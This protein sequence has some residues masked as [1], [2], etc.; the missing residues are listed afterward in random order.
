VYFYFFYFHP[1]AENGTVAGERHVSVQKAATLG[2]SLT[3]GL[4]G[5]LSF[6]SPL[7]GTDPFMWTSFDFVFSAMSIG[8]ASGLVAQ[9]APNVLLRNAEVN[10][11]DAE[12]EMV[13]EGGDQSTFFSSS[14]PPDFE[15]IRDVEELQR[16]N[17]E[18]LRWEESEKRVWN[19]EKRQRWA[20]QLWEAQHFRRRER[21]RVLEQAE[22][23]QAR[24][25]SEE[26]RER[27]RRAQWGPRS[28]QYA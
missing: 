8:A 9:M 24:R 1:R 20:Q 23:D 26:F 21:R 18:W 16:T 12:M 5:V 28:T 15:R 25:Q 22:R 13:G 2:G 10:K 17:L 19:A 6:V 27:K 3:L 11:F 4:M 7:V 14:S